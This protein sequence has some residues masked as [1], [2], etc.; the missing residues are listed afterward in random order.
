MP[1]SENIIT[2]ILNLCSIFFNFWDN[3]YTNFAPKNYAKKRFFYFSVIYSNEIALFFI[4]F[5]QFAPIS[6][7]NCIFIHTTT[8]FCRCPPHKKLLFIC[9]DCTLFQSESA[10]QKEKHLYF[11]RCFM[12]STKLMLRS[13]SR[14]R[15]KILFSF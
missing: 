7:K 14:F 1:L 11:N 8:A 6:Q 12:V 5:Q 9:H 15:L 4:F 10:P 3:F 2:H 13:K